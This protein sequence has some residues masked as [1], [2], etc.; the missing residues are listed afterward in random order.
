MYYKNYNELYKLKNFFNNKNC[1]QSEY[2]KNKCYKINQTMSSYDNYYRK[3]QIINCKNYCKNNC[4]F[5]IN[6]SK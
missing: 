4:I 6:Y 5:K 2:N 3:I 1:C